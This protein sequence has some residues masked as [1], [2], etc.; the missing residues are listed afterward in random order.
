MRKDY[1]SRQAE[2]NQ[3]ENEA[4]G[5]VQD[6]RSSLRAK[7]SSREELQGNLKRLKE[8]IKKVQGEIDE[9]PATDTDIE[10]ARK[11]HSDL[12][13]RLQEL[14]EELQAAGFDDKIRERNAEVR[15]L[16]EIREELTTELNA[17][18]RQA[19]FRAKLDMNL[20]AAH[21]KQKEAEKLLDRHADV[22]ERLIGRRP[23][24]DTLEPD[25]LLVSNQREKSLT[26]LEHAQLESNNRVQRLQSTMSYSR[27]QLDKKVNA[28]SDLESRI[29]SALEGEEFSSVEDAISSCQQEVDFAKKQLAMYESMTDFFENANRHSKEKKVC[30]GCNRGIAAGDLDAVEAYIADMIRKSKPAKQEEYRADL[31]GWQEQLEMFIELKPVAAQLESLKEQDIIK[32][33]H[34]T[35]SLENQLEEAKGDAEKCTEAVDESKAQMRELANLKRVASEVA[36]LTSE[37]TQLEKDAQTIENDLRS[38]G[39]VRT[40]DQVQQEIDGLADRIKRSKRDVSTLIQEKETKRTSIMSHERK[41]HQAEMAVAQRTQDHRN[42]LALQERAEEMRDE[43]GESHARLRRLEGDIEKAS[44]PIQRATGELETIKREAAAQLASAQEKIREVTNHCK[45]LEDSRDAAQV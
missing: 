29:T 26:D 6:L 43:Q 21:D 11:E 19:D 16:E 35:G 32:L 15:D 45:Q 20:K 31:A 42:L 37:S 34:E 25:V 23:P 1:D 5:K 8:R 7:E 14:N 28:A 24:S 10:S 12:E 36:R 4:A 39:T 17:L 33:K 9:M 13:K 2:F 44:E 22:L 38:T 18:N 41:V 27:E 40:G 3:K 30:L